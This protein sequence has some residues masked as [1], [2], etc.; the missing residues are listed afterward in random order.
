MQAE[1]I[2]RQRL[3]GAA[4]EDGD[5]RHAVLVEQQPNAR[6]EGLKL[7]RTRNAAFGEPD[8]ALFLLEYCRGQREAADDATSRIDRQDARH[9]T[10]GAAKGAR[11]A[12]A[13]PPA[14][15]GVP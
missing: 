8:Q 2:R 14:P 1:G 6:A 10:E 4:D 5:H 3:L 7:T 11:E 12:D 13:D 9:S 15:V